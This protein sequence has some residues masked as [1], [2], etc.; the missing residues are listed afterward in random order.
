MLLSIVGEALKD[1]RMYGWEFDDKVQHNWVTLRDNVQCHI[2]SLNWNYKTQ[3]RTK[4]VK[5]IN[6]LGEFVDSHTIKVTYIVVHLLLLWCR[7]QT[8]RELNLL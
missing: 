6:S 5:Y 1:A 4:N 7:P 8:Q 3:L 2:A